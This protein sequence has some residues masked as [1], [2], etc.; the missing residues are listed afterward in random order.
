MQKSMSKITTTISQAK[1][2]LG[3]GM[4][5]MPENQE[6]M[7]VCSEEKDFFDDIPDGGL[8][9][10]QNKPRS[11]SWKSQKSLGK[12]YESKSVNADHVNSNVQPFSTNAE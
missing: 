3:K 10:L 12:N 9:G 5:C 2:L 6:E 1:N 7:D 8:R 11:V 4:M